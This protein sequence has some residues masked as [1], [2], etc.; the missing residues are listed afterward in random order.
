[1]TDYFRQ[2]KAW[3]QDLITRQL[4]KIGEPVTVEDAEAMRRRFIELGT[5]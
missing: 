3:F 1:M 5:G 4:N 2:A